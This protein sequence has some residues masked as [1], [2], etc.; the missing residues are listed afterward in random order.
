MINDKMLSDLRNSVSKIVSAKRFS[1][2]CGVERCAMRLGE[3]IIPERLAEVRAAAL[4]HDISKELP[5]QEQLR[6]LAEDG[7]PLEAEDIETEGVLHSFTAPIV[8]ARDFPEYATA[9]ILSATRNHTVGR[10]NMSIFEKIIFVSD[11]AED[12]RAYESCIRV[13]ERLFEGFEALSLEEKIARLDEACIN[14]IDGALS[15]LKRMGCPIN[16]RMY[17]TRESLLR[18]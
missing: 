10:E 5:H 18:K 12:T 17:K 1:H 9:D 4:L 15:A 11:Y 14:S 2:I 6:L 7:F 13:R 8:I 3:A 16:S